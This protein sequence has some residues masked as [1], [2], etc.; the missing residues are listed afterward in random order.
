MLIA[1]RF[2][3]F[4]CPDESDSCRRYP[5]CNC[6]KDS[7]YDQHTNMCWSCPENSFGEFPNCACTNKKATFDLGFVE[8][9]NCPADSDQ[10][11][12]HPNCDCS[13]VGIYN[14]FENKCTKCPSNSTGI[15]PNCECIDKTAGFRFNTC[16][17]C[18]DNSIGNYPNCTCSD[19]KA[20]YNMNLNACKYCPV[21]SSGKIPNCVC[22]DGAGLLA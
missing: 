21:D 5:N 19:E 20:T 22:S 4:K 8:C 18:P 17:K 11:R 7:L 16:E 9:R 3:C 14:Q 2:K 12:V 13:K 1:A 6:P 15:Y 10:T